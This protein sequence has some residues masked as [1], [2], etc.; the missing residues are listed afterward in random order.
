MPVTSIVRIKVKAGREADFETIARDLAATCNANE[1]GIRFYQAFRT[2]DS[3]AYCFLE[4]F[5]DEQALKAHT[6]SD[7]FR[8][9]RAG[10]VDCFD[11]T[12]EIQ[13][14]SDI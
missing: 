1:P 4:S 7:H 6:S 8:A 2:G 10:L 14:L 5:A 13:R 11:G 12:P 9:A 3:G